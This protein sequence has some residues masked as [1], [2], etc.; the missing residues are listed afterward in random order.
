[1][2]SWKS[3]IVKIKSRCGFCGEV[4]T[5]W[6]DRNDHLSDHFRE[7]ALMKEW[8]G[9]RGL[10]P[11]IALL[12][13]NAIPPYLI[14]TE[15][16]DPDPFSA[17]RPGSKSFSQAN[18]NRSSP[19][20][21]FEEL[22]A[23]LGEYVHTTISNGILVTDELL[24]KEA[25]VILYGDE[26][27]WN[28]TPA[29]NPQ[30]LHMFKLGYGLIVPLA[31]GLPSAPPSGT[32][33]GEILQSIIA[34]LPIGMAPFTAQN[35][36]HAAGDSAMLLPPVCNINTEGCE[37]AT[38]LSTYIP[39]SWQTPECLAEFRQMG[40]NPMLTTECSNTACGLLAPTTFNFS[41]SDEPACLLSPQTYPFPAPLLD[42][43]DAVTEPGGPGS[44][45]ALTDTFGVNPFPFNA[46]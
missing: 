34:T 5:K 10:E 12:V 32:A 38:T 26:D 33:G 35:M 28:Q 24:R 43:L 31:A 17:L 30:W 39:W 15:A 45:E 44:M 2:D 13:E 6:S 42:S 4:F 8:K 22:T 3:E 23:R 40:C 16:T 19:R 18:A 36:Q 37:S 41:T 25:R 29:D 9:C 7:G 14:G 21:T 20:T 27:P 46:G 11:A 1:M